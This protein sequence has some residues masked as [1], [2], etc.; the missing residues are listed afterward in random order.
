MAPVPSQEIY[1]KKHPGE[2]IADFYTLLKDPKV[3]QLLNF[4]FPGSLEEAEQI[5]RAR[6]QNAGLFFGVFLSASPTYI[7][8]AELIPGPNSTA[9][10]GYVLSST[11]WGKGYGTE[12]SKLLVKMGFEELGYGKIIAHCDVENYASERLMI[13][14][15]MQKERVIPH[16]RYIRGQWRDSL[17]YAIEK[18]DYSPPSFNK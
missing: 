15:G 10:M 16:H 8:F 13:K 5:L 17:R 12:V 18:S 7:G 9:E 1:L 11:Y 3:T 4:P 2:R 14:C 6:I